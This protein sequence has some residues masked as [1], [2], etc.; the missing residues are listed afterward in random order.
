MPS[1]DDGYGNS[2]TGPRGT[3]VQN[4]PNR[5]DGSKRK[6]AGVPIGTSKE[7]VR[8]LSIAN[9]MATAEEWE[10]WAPELTPSVKKQ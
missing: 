10:Q 4:F 8:E 9:G 6:L 1:I 2:N 5:P 7:D 3:F